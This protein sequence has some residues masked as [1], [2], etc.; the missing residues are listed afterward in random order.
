MPEP[1][2]HVNPLKR[3]KF[4]SE[5][6]GAPGNLYFQHRRGQSFPLWLVRAPGVLSPAK[7]LLCGDY[8]WQTLGDRLGDEHF[9]IS[10]KNGAV[11]LNLPV[12]LQAVNRF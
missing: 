10:Q 7:R 5:S 3:P 12:D 8:R 11:F 4:T 1:E 6:R 9:Y 2:N